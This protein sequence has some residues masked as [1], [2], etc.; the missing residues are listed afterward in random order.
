MQIYN[1]H[2]IF[3]RGFLDDL[4]K[5]ASFNTLYTLTYFYQL[6]IQTLPQCHNSVIFTINEVRGQRNSLWKSSDL[7]I[8][9]YAEKSEQD[10]NVDD[11]YKVPHHRCIMNLF[12]ATEKIEIG[13]NSQE[14]M[15]ELNFN[16][17]TGNGQLF[18]LPQWKTIISN[19]KKFS[20]LKKSFLVFHNNQKNIK[21]QIN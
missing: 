1:V 18:I 4:I 7:Y 16:F 21:K 19:S 6:F 12:W 9:Y 10:E 14:F 20:Y 2:S 15:W 17:F 11:A 8:G 3:K 5:N 13:E